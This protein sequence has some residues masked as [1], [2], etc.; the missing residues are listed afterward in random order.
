MSRGPGRWQRV[1]LEE[2]GR[3]D[4][5]PIADVV[6]NHTGQ[7]PTRSDMTA[8]RLAAKRLAESGRVRAIYLLRCT[9]CSELF[10]QWDYAHGNRRRCT[11]GHGTRALVLTP[12]DS[13]VETSRSCP[14]GVPDWI[15]P[16]KAWVHTEAE[17]AKLLAELEAKITQA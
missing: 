15:T 12:L 1:L 14:D 5:V 16:R 4:L 8:A 13:D 17:R 11:G 6:Y 2:V 3:R 10:E 9:V 7:S